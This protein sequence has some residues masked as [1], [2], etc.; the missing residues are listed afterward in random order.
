MSKSLTVRELLNGGDE[1][2][3]PLSIDTTELK[4]LSNSIP[5]DGNIDINIAEELATKY[6][7]GSDICSE[8]LAIA[9]THVQKCDTE[10]KRA[11]GYAASVKATASGTKTDK[12]RAWF[13][14][15]DE[16][17]IKAC[18]KYA[19]ATGFM[20]WVSG[21][22]E[23]F[24][25]SHYMCKKMLDRGY[26]HERQGGWNGTDGSIPSADVEK[27]EEAFDPGW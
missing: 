6:L 26:E 1:C 27:K 16:D 24:I 15:Q 4:E 20:K 25:K 5:K 2:F 23:S 17:Y 8:L 13:A 11:Y 10:R 9:V 12:A 3:D 7:R 14:D 18:N 22:L 21:K 19:E